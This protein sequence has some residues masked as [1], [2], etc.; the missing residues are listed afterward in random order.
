MNWVS[1]IKALNILKKLVVSNDCMHYL[2]STF[3]NETARNFVPFY[4]VYPL[5]NELKKCFGFLRKKILEIPYSAKFIKN[6]CFKHF[7]ICHSTAEFAF[8]FLLYTFFEYF[9][10]DGN[11]SH[12]NVA[13]NFNFNFLQKCSLNTYAWF[14]NIRMEW[15]GILC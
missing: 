12:K 7:P 10:V 14:E 9:R 11:R 13:Q 5:D 4:T 1:R 8:E 3:P 6:I 2:K 15:L